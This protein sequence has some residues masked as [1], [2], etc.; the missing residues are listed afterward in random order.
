MLYL[1]HFRLHSTWLFNISVC[2]IMVKYTKMMPGC[3][4]QTTGADCYQLKLGHN[5]PWVSSKNMAR[6]CNIKPLMQIT[7]CQRCYIENC[8]WSAT[9]EIV[10]SKKWIRDL[11]LVVE[12]WKWA[13]KWKFWATAP[14][15]SNLRH[16]CERTISWQSKSCFVK[17]FFEC[18]REFVRFVRLVCNNNISI[19]IRFTCFK[20]MFLRS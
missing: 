5:L 12:T 16:S 9:I 17:E 3:K 4:L 7:P 19:W 1:V 13:L 14:S 15:S 18:L 8:W 10:D 6:K 20:A 11:T 2:R